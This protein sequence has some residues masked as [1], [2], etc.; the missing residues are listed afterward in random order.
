MELLCLSPQDPSP[1]GHLSTSGPCRNRKGGG[2]HHI[3]AVHREGVELLVQPTH[4]LMLEEVA[5]LPVELKERHVLL[6]GQ[7]WG[8]KGIQGGGL[9]L[10]LHTAFLPSLSRLVKGEVGRTM[11]MRVSHVPA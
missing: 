1:P 8:N 3:D 6:H 11:K 2:H 7:V 4:E 5:A 9:A 10:G